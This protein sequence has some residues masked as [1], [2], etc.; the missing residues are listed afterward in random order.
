VQERDLRGP[1]Y[2][3]NDSD[4]LRNEALDIC[5]FNDEVARLYKDSPRA[6]S[7]LPNLA[8]LSRYCVALARYLQRPMHEHAALETM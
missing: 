2:E 7:E 1:G 3:D 4:N 8:P 6:L 5:L